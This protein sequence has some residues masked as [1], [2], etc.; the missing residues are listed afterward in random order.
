[1]KGGLCGQHVP[2]DYAITAAA[3]T[4]ICDGADICEHSMQV[5]LHHW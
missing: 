5:L 4:N 3:I 2:S 1:M